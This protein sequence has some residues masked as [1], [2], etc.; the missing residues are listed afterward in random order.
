[1]QLET[2]TGLILLGRPLGILSVLLIVK[3]HIVLAH[4][5]VARQLKTEV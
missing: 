5:S 2:K 1:M 4:S 3:M